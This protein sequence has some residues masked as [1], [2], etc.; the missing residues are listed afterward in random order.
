VILAAQS[1]RYLRQWKYNGREVGRF[2]LS[3]MPVGV[4][5]L[6]VASEAQGIAMHRTADQVQAENPQNTQKE[7]VEQELLE[8]W[9]GQHVIFVRY[10]GMQSPH[11]E[12]IYNPAD[13]DAAPVNLGARFGPDRE[14]AAPTL[15]CRAILLAFQTG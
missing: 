8:K 13:I 11:E 14:R 2:L 7:S 1:M 12:W 15:L 5:L 6:M 3:A 9:L 10:T 4:L